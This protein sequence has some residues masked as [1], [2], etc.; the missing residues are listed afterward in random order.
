MRRVLSAVLTLAACSGADPGAARF[1]KDQ[2]RM[3]RVVDEAT[4]APVV[5]A[6]DIALSDPAANDPAT[7][8]ISAYDRLADEP[9]G[10]YRL[11]LDALAE[12]DPAVRPVLGDVRPHGLAASGASAARFISRKPDGAAVVELVVVTPGGV[13][14]EVETDVP[15]GANDL[16]AVRETVTYTVDREVCK[17]AIRE[18][19]FAARAGRVER[20]AG[21]DRPAGRTLASGLRLPNGIAG[22]RGDIWVAE[23]L[24]K[25]LVLLGGERT[26]A[27]PGAPDNLNSSDE[28]IVAALQPSLWRFGLYRYGYA[29]RAPT[30]IVLVDPETDEVEL[31]FEDPNGRLLP[32]ATAA[33]LKDGLMVAS[34]VRGTALLVCGASA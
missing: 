6:E 29:K 4:G 22:W 30:R 1:T 24:E 7:L 26:I 3:V 19:L 5:G 14:R 17:G 33:V 2:C 15:C 12:A 20:T 31:L 10:V 13:V 21:P 9:G 25:R 16:V 32:G 8:W 23:M 11:A 34:S 28:G 27:L 18:R